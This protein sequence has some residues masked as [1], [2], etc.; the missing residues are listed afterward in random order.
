MKEKIEIDS[1]LQYI[2]NNIPSLKNG[3]IYR[4]DNMSDNW[5]EILVESEVILRL[6]LKKNSKEFKVITD[7]ELEES[8]FQQL[9]IFKK[10]K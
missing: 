9:G 1:W 5:F 8:M 10:E 6:D 4:V 7:R 2:G 3:T